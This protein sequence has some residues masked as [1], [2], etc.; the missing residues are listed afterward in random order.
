MSSTADHEPHTATA[1]GQDSACHETGVTLDC[2]VDTGRTEAWRREVWQARYRAQ[3]DARRRLAERYGS[4]LEKGWIADPNAPQVDAVSLLY[5]FLIKAGAASLRTP[6]IEQAPRLQR[7]DALAAAHMIRVARR[8]ASERE[9]AGMRRIL[10]HGVTW[11]ELAHT[12]DAT[13]N[14][15]TRLLRQQGQQPDTWAASAGGDR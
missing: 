2:G 12:L 7:D 11:D 1:V 5:A 10:A 4:D 8:D 14:E 3:E 6:D 13:P 9:A 15:L